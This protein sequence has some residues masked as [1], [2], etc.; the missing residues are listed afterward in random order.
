M[1]LF[2]ILWL[3]IIIPFACI[4][5]QAAL[6]AIIYVCGTF[7]ITIIEEIQVSCAVHRARKEKIERKMKCGSCGA[8]IKKGQKFCTN[9][10]TKVQK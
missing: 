7:Y 8:A 1:T 6:G 2:I 3:I 10:G 5:L 4:F 9:C